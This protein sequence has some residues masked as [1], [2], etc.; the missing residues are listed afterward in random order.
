MMRLATHPDWAN[1]LSLHGSRIYVRRTAQR[2][3]GKAE[4]AIEKRDT[5][6]R[7]KNYQTDDSD[8]LIR[9]PG[10]QA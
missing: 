8:I 7:I 10:D 5:A 1:E 3:W 2:L 6:M 9:L 4:K